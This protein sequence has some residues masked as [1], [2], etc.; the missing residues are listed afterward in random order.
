MLLII[1]YKK[2]DVIN[3]DNNIENNNSFLSTL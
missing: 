1:L 3:T 2:P